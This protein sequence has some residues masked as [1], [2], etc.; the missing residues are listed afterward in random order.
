[1]AVEA[2]HA[3]ALVQLAVLVDSLELDAHA[4]PLKDCRGV[5]ATPVAL[6]AMGMRGRLARQSWEANSRTN[7][8]Q[9]AGSADPITGI[10]VG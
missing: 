5:M 7:D 10:A 8:H 3:G 2:A 9:V 6:R 1:M 4:A